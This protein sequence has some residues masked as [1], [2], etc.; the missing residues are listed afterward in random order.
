[1]KSFCLNISKWYAVE[2]RKQKMDATL[3]KASS[4]PFLFAR[5]RCHKNFLIFL[6]G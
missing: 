3:W 4:R 1:M 6:V 5:W 2:N